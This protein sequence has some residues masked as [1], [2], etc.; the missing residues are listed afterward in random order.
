M[1]SHT[2]LT[3]TKLTSI[4]KKFGLT[5]VKQDAFNKIKRIVDRYTLLNYPDFNETF[6]IHID[7]SAFR[8]GAV[9]RQK[10][11]PITFYSI[12]LTGSQQWY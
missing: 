11:K 2:L 5:Q 1:R 3:L 8:L 10:G 6:K 7:A 4:K 9:T 12:Q